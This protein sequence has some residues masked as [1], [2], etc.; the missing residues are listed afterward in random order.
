M[1]HP[2]PTSMEASEDEDGGADGA[3]APLTAATA[4]GRPAA[5]NTLASRA[6]CISRAPSARCRKRATEETSESR[7]STLREVATAPEDEDEDEENE[8]DPLEEERGGISLAPAATSRGTGASVPTTRR[9]APVATPAAA[10]T[11]AATATA[12]GAPVPAA[13]PARRAAPCSRARRARRTNSS[14]LSH[15]HFSAEVRLRPTRPRSASTRSQLRN[16]GSSPGCPTNQM[17][18]AAGAQPACGTNHCRKS[19]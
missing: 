3:T 1:E 14:A 16:S 19:S 17:W 12:A 8:E 18:L 9:A 2:R 7:R 13:I 10:G 6:A 11:P 5:P 15:A 4:E